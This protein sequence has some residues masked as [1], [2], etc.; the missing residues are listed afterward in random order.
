MGTDKSAKNTPNAPKLISAPI[1]C[2]SPKVWNFDEKRLHWASTV[3]AQDKTHKT[4]ERV[5]LLILAKNFHLLFLLSCSYRKSFF[6]ANALTLPVRCLFFKRAIKILLACFTCGGW[7]TKLPI[8]TK[9]YRKIKDTFY[10][11]AKREVICVWVPI[12]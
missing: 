11:K 7:S 6:T 12:Y 4:K 3:R 1:V 5:F 8:A 2:L 10:L 9:V